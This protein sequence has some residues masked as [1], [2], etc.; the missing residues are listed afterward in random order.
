MR[1]KTTPLETVSINT[2]GTATY[3]AEDREL[4]ITV[5][6]DVA[7]RLSRLVPSD[8]QEETPAIHLPSA[9][10]A[11]DGKQVAVSVS[12]IF[13][14]QYE[15]VTYYKA[16]VSSDAFKDTTIHLGHALRG[17]DV[18]S[19][20]S[21][22]LAWLAP[23]I[24]LSA[25]AYIAFACAE[26]YQHFGSLPWTAWTAVPF[27]IVGTL[28]ALTFHRKSTAYAITAALFTCAC[29]AII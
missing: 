18:E 9:Y 27:A 28:I 2:T 17:N 4:L 10:A 23:V 20:Q 21:L 6:K 8:R 25:F 29:A 13:I 16:D 26:N 14:M 7:K 3:N 5:P 24:A 22:N 15:F 19:K 1:F 12:N 11:L